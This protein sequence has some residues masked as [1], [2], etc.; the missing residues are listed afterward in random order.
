MAA[1]VLREREQIDFL[2]AKIRTAANA[3]LTANPN[4]DKALNI[5]RILRRKL[6]LRDCEQILSDLP[7]TEVEVEAMDERITDLTKTTTASDGQ[8]VRHHHKSNKEHIN[9][10]RITLKKE[11]PLSNL[12]APITIPELLSACP[13]AAEFSL[14]KIETIHDVVAHARTLAP[15]IGITSQNYEAAHELLGALRAAATVWAIMQFHDKIKAVGAY[16]RSIT[17]GSKSEGFSPEKLIRR[18]ATAQNYAV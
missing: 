12:E 4:D 16:F 11:I 8:F 5:F 7:V 6:S 14:R 2:R 9:K 1:E 18:L 13:G 17:T 10:K 15:M 3:S